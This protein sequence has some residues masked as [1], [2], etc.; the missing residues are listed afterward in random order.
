MVRTPRE[1]HIDRH[2]VNQAKKSAH[3]MILGS[4]LTINNKNN[5]KSKTRG[6]QIENYCL[7]SL[8]TSVHTVKTETGEKD[9]ILSPIISALYITPSEQLSNPDN[10][11]RVNHDQV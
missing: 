9:N 11:R 5:C 1:Q 2:R 10:V 6:E 4:L 3:F 7:N 8:L